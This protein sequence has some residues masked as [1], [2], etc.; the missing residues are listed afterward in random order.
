MGIVTTIAPI[1][2]ALLMLGLGASLT[3]ADFL[4][5]LKNPKD[6]FIGFVCQLFVLPL[7]A[8]LLVILLKVPIELALGVMLIAAAPGG[9]TSNV[10]T[11]R[12]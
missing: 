5:V 6:F 4:R 12:F 1:A 8:Y 7:V 2:L 9:V 10:L 3:V 11:I